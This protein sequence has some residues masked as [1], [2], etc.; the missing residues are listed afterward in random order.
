MI[1]FLIFIFNILSPVHGIGALETFDFFGNGLKDVGS[2]DYATLQNDPIA[3][4]PDEFTVCSSIYMKSY[5][6]EQSLVQLL[7]KDG[8]PW[9]SLYFLHLNETSMMHPY[10]IGVHGVY[11]HFTKIKA[12]PLQ[13]NHAC[14]GINTVTG[15]LTTSINNEVVH[16][17]VMD[18]FVGSNVIAPKNL[19]SNVIL[20]KWFFQG[21]WLQSL[22]VSSNINIFGRKLSNI[23]MLLITNGTNCGLEGDYISWKD[24]KWENYNSNILKYKI[25][26]TEICNQEKLHKFSLPDNVNWYECQKTCTKFQNSHMPSLNNHERSLSVANWFMDRMFAKDLSGNVSPFPSGCVRFW[27][28]ITDVVEDGVWVDYN[29]GKEVDFFEWKKGEPNGKTSQNCGNL[30]PPSGW[31]DRPC[32][33]GK[34]CICE[35]EKQPILKLRGLCQ[36]SKIDT[37]FVLEN[38]KHSGKLIYTGIYGT[39]IVYNEDDLTWE[40]TIYRDQQVITKAIT[41]APKQSLL[42][43]TYNWKIYND[44][45]ECTIEESYTARLT[46]SGCSEDQFTCSDGN[47]INMDNRCDGKVD[48]Q[49]T[50]DEIDCNVLNMKDSYNKDIS[51]P[52]LS[53]E[54]LVNIDVSIIMDTILKIDEIDEVFYLSFKLITQ[55]FDSR[56]VYNNLKR[57]IDLNVLTPSQQVSIWSPQ[58]IF[59]NTKTKKK[60]TLKDATVRILPNPRF[61]YKKADITSTNNV[62]LFN[63]MENKIEISQVYDIDFI[64]QYDMLLY[65]F[66]TQHCNMDFV[67]TAVLDNFCELDVANFSYTGPLDLRQY[68]IRYGW[69][70]L[71]LG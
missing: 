16:N 66:D 50:S 71:E 63:G 26:Q 54:G 4:L 56:L 3:N 43:G 9:F 51:P 19:T 57:K 13:W 62:Y 22:G 61:T 45:R 67:L 6:M 8:D 55:W 68:F 24:M 11:I 31:T 46:M 70:K 23:E 42:L 39:K 21:K 20:G 37:I 44:S 10:C 15:D 2:L 59:D 1:L 12:T 17:G 35:N 30:V 34:C 40:A 69:H 64:C 65:P 58:I 36:N 18:H 38:P 60:S 32:D 25:P 29:T 48:C 33:V 47:C 5:I 28:P 53:N 27:L 14:I 49:D 7:T 41:A 52:T